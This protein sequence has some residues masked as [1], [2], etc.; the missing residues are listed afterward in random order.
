M[1]YPEDPYAA[2]TASASTQPTGR[3]KPPGM[4]IWSSPAATVTAT[5]APTPNPTVRP[6]SPLVA[7]PP[8]EPRSYLD[9]LGGM[10]SRRR[11]SRE[12]R[13]ADRWF[14]PDTGMTDR[15]DAVADARRAEQR[16]AA[17]EAERAA[18]LSEREQ[19][20]AAEMAQKQ[21]NFEVDQE[22]KRLGRDTITNPEGDRVYTDTMTDW[23]V[24]KQAEQEDALK[25]AEYRREGRSFY[26]DP[27]TK[28][29]APEIPD[30]EWRARQQERAATDRSKAIE[31]ARKDL[32]TAE[33][34]T[35]DTLTA[36]ERRRLEA[37]QSER[38]T[39]IRAAL[40]ERLASDPAATETTGGFLGFGAR[41]TDRAASLAARRNELETGGADPTPEEWAALEQDEAWRP[42]VQEYRQAQAQLA[43]DDEN[44]A[45]H[46]DRERRRLDQARDAMAALTGAPGQPANRAEGE[47]PTQPTRR[48]AVH[49]T[50]EAAGA[51]VS[52]PNQA[53]G[54]Q[55]PEQKPLSPADYNAAAED[56]QYAAE[57]LAQRDAVLSDQIAMLDQ[58]AAALVERGLSE[59]E[60]VTLP[61]GRVYPRA[62]VP[63]LIDL[64]EKQFAHQ[65]D[66]ASERERLAAA[67]EPLRL[68]GEQLRQQVE[69][70]R[71]E[72]R[73]QRAQW[74]AD[75]R[76]REPA[77]APVADEIEA[78][79]RE[80][81]S[82]IDRAREQFEPGPE[83]AAAL[84]T[85]T[86]DTE[87]RSGELIQRV[88]GFEGVRD[89]IGQL[90]VSTA[91]EM[92]RLDAFHAQDPASRKT[93]ADERQQAFSDAWDAA[94]ELAKQAGLP[95]SVVRPVWYDAFHASQP[96]I[97]GEQARALHGSGRALI[98]PAIAFDDKA[99]TAALEKLEA[100]ASAKQQAR[101]NLPAMRRRLAVQLLPTLRE[102]GDFRR[103]EAKNAHR[104]RG[105]DDDPEAGMG[106]QAE[107]EMATAYFAEMTP[108]RKVL[109][110]VAEGL[111]AGAHDIRTQ[112]HALPAAVSTLLADHWLPGLQEYAATARSLAEESAARAQQ[113]AAAAATTPAQI[114]P[115]VSVADLSRG[116]TS[117]APV[118]ATGGLTGGLVRAGAA[119]SLGRIG[120]AALRLSGGGAAVSGGMSATQAANLA[121]QIGLRGASGMAFV[122]SFGGT[123]VDARKNYLDQG[124]S[125]TEAGDAALRNATLAGLT[126]FALTRLGGRFGP[127][128]LLAGDITSSRTAMGAAELVKQ[129]A[130][131]TASRQM[132]KREL[133]NLGKQLFLNA[134]GEGIEEWADETIQ[135]L[136]TYGT[137]AQ[138]GMTLH[139][140][141]NQGM[142][143]GWI[144][145]GLGGGTVAIQES[146]GGMAGALDVMRNRGAARA[147]QKR[148]ED[149][150]ATLA[151]IDAWTGPDRVPEGEQWTDQDTAAAKARA[152]ALTRIAAGVDPATLAPEELAAVGLQKKGGK[153]EAAK[154]GLQMADYE[155]EPMSQVEIGQEGQ[156]TLTPASRKWLDTY[157]PKV[158]RLTADLET[159]TQTQTNEQDPAP[160][161]D[162]PGQDP[163]PSQEQQVPQSGDLSALPAQEAAAAGNEPEP[164][165][166]VPETPPAGLTAPSPVVDA[167]LSDPQPNPVASPTAPSLIENHEPR[168]KNQEQQTQQTLDEP[169]T[170]H[171]RVLANLLVDSRQWDPAD[172]RAVAAEHVARVGI[173]EA[174]PRVQM[175]KHLLPEIEQTL[176]AKGK[177]ATSGAEMGQR[178]AAAMKTGRL[179]VE[180]NGRVGD[181]EPAPDT[182]P[183]SYTPQPTQTPEPATPGDRRS[184][185]STATRRALADRAADLEALGITIRERDENEDGPQ[186]IWADPELGEIAIRP[187]VME[188]WYGPL[189]GN[190]GA[191]ALQIAATI[192][193]ELEHFA[194]FEAGLAMI[195]DAR[196]AQGKDPL[197]RR[198]AISAFKGKMTE[199]WKDFEQR[200]ARTAE[201]FGKLYNP[202][203]WSQ[204]PAYSRGMEVA[205]MLRQR[206]TGRFG[207]M[208]TEQVYS[209][210]FGNRSQITE[211]SA[212]ALEHVLGLKNQPGLPLT[213]K[214]RDILRAVADF[215]RGIVGQ[216]KQGA[217]PQKGADYLLE[218]LEATEAVLETRRGK[219][220]ETGRPGDR[221]TQPS[222]PATGDFIIR[223]SKPDEVWEIT[224]IIR[225]GNE[226]TIY[227]RKRGSRGSGRPIGTLDT[228][229]DNWQP[230]PKE[231]ARA[232]MRREVA[233]VAG[234]RGPDTEGSGTSRSMRFSGL[235][236]MMSPAEWMQANLSP[237][238]QKLAADDQVNREALLTD[239]LDAIKVAVQKGYPI[240]ESARDYATRRG[241]G[242]KL[243][244][245]FFQYRRDSEVGAYVFP[246]KTSPLQNSE[247]PSLPDSPSSKKRATLTRRPRAPRDRDDTPVLNY[248]RESKI[249]AK[250]HPGAMKRMAAMGRARKKG[251]PP[252]PGDRDYFAAWDGAPKLADQPAHVRPYL[253]GIFSRTQGLP[254]DEMA[255]ELASRGLI[256]PDGR[257]GDMY[258]AIDREL[259]TIDRDLAPRGRDEQ[260]NPIV[261]PEQQAE[262]FARDVLSPDATKEERLTNELQPG[263]KLT[264]EGGETLRVDRVLQDGRVVLSDGQTY[265]TQIIQEE[266]RI[267]VDLHQRENGEVVEVDPSLQGFGAG[268][269]ADGDLET[270]RQGNGESP[271]FQVS[272][273]PSLPLSEYPLTNGGTLRGPGLHSLPAAPPRLYH[274]TP[275]K[276]DRFSLDKIGTGEGAQVYGWGLY[277]AEEQK[278]ARG[279]RDGLSRRQVVYRG[280][281]GED[282]FP[283]SGD[284]GSLHTTPKSV[285]AIANGIRSRV[286]NG[287]EFTA[288]LA[289][290]IIESRKRTL[291]QMISE[292]SSGLV[293]FQ[294]GD[295][296]DLIFPNG[297]TKPV[298]NAIRIL[299]ENRDELDQI[300]ANDFTYDSGNLYTIELEADEDEFLDW[301][302]PLSEQSETVQKNLF[303]LV[304]KY[305]IENDAIVR[306]DFKDA[307]LD[308]SVLGSKLYFTI[309]GERQ[310]ET[311]ASDS[312]KAG[313]EILKDS[314]IRGIRYLDGSSRLNPKSLEE[315]R[316][317]VVIARR[318]AENAPQN[319][320]Y[321]K[322]LKDEEGRLAT[323]EQDAQRNTRNYV[324][325]DESIIRIREENGQPVN[326]AEDTAARLNAARPRLPLADNDIQG[327]F[328]F[329]GIPESKQDAARADIDATLS[330]PPGG[331]MDRAASP[332]GDEDRRAAAR[333]HQASRGTAEGIRAAFAGGEQSVSA[334]IH[335]LIRRETPSFEIRGAVIESAEDFRAFLLP[336]RSPFVESVK[337]AVIGDGNQVIHSQ[338]VSIGSVNEAM[339]PRSSI[340]GIIETARAANPDNTV[341]G[342]LIA[343]NHP[344]G[345]VE[346][347]VADRTITN[348]LI[349]DGKLIGVPLLDHVITNGREY[350]SFLES[351]L[352]WGNRDGMVEDDAETSPRLPVLPRP[353]IQTMAP[354]EAQSFNDLANLKD[355][356][357]L[358]PWLES[359]KTGD[360][361]HHHILFVDTRM[362]LRAIERVPTASSPVDLSAR[363]LRGAGREGAAGFFISLANSKMPDANS[364]GVVRELRQR[365]GG[366]DLYFHD[367][368]IWRSGNE[369][370]F[371][372]REMGLMEESPGSLYAARPSNFD[373]TLADLEKRVARGEILTTAERADLERRRDAAGMLAF[374]LDDATVS[375]ET[376]QQRRQREE[377]EQRR[378]QRLIGSDAGEDTDLFT[379]GT[380]DGQ[381]LLFAA[382]PGSRRNG[383]GFFDFGLSGELTN[384]PNQIA[385]DFTAPA[386]VSP[387]PLSTGSGRAG[388]HAGDV[389][390]VHPPE[391]A[392]TEGTATIIGEVPSPN[393]ADP[394]HVVRFE[395]DPSQQYTR[396]ESDF[397]PA[398]SPATTQPDL[399]PVAPAIGVNRDFGEKIGDARKDLAEKS[400]RT[401]K[402]K[403]AKPDA[404]PAWMKGWDIVQIVSEV[405]RWG[406]ST[407]NAGKWTFS[408]D[409][410]RRNSFYY[411]RNPVYDTRKE[412]ERMLP[413]FVV[414]QK[415]RVYRDRDNETQYA[416]FRNVTDRKRVVIKGGF[417]T[418]EDALRYMAENAKE[419]LET[420]TGH[421]EEILSPR[422]DQPIYRKGPS[423]RTRPADAALFADTF[424][425][426]GVEFGN[427]VT[428]E[429]GQDVL[430]HA[431][432]G[433]MDLAEFLNV[434]PRALSLNGEL[435]LAF[436][437]R[438]QGLSGARA[439]YERDRVV[440][441]LTKMKG[442]GSLAHEWMHAVDHYFARQEGRA[443]SEWEYLPD[444]TRRLKAKAADSDFMTAGDY[445]RTSKLRPEVA[446]AWK[447]LREIMTRK[448]VQKEID[449]TQAQKWADKSLNEM[450]GQL[451]AVRAGLAKE[452]PYGSRKAPATADQLARWDRAVESL[453]SGGAGEL[454]WRAI[455]NSAAKWGDYAW[456]NDAFDELSKIHKEVRNRAG[457]KKEGGAL[458]YAIGYYRDYRRREKKLEMANAGEQETQMV[459]TEYAR[460]AHLGD[461]GR[462]GDYWS[463]PW[464]MAARAFSSYIEDKAAASSVHSGFLSMGSTEADN[465]FFKMFYGFKPYP[466]KAERTAIN[467]ALDGLFGSLKT[468]ETDTGTRL[469]A[470]RPVQSLLDT[471]PA[472]PGALVNG[473]LQGRTL[474]ESATE[475]GYP[476][477]VTADPDRL[478]RI[479][480]QT[481]LVLTQRAQSAGLTPEQVREGFEAIS[482]TL[483][484]AAPTQNQAQSTKNKR[485]PGQSA[486]DSAAI[487]LTA[488]VGRASGFTGLADSL[489]R[490]YESAPLAR[491]LRKIIDIAR[492][493]AVPLHLLDREVTSHMAEM[494]VA[495]A[496]GQE[497][498]MDVL[499][500]VSGRAKFSD[501]AWPKQY[502][503]DAGMRRRLWMAMTGNGPGLDT[504]PP[505]VATIGRRMRTLLED[506]G[507]KAVREGRM[508]PDTF[509]DLRGTYLPE[510]YLEHELAQTN[511][512]VGIFRKLKLGMNEILAQRMTGFRIEDTE[513]KD[514]TGQ[515]KLVTYT[516]P[517]S[518]RQRWRFRDR[519]H[520]DAYWE[521]YT[522][523]RAVEAMQH[524]AQTAKSGLPRAEQDA[525]RALPPDALDR[526]EQLPDVIRGY[527]AGHLATMRRRYRREKPLTIA[528]REKAG[529]IMDPVYSV[530][531]YL[532]HM[533]H[534]NATAKFFHIL[535]ADAT[536]KK[537]IGPAN[538]DGYTQIPDHAKF[539]ALRSKWVKNEIASQVME[540]VGASSD[541]MRAYDA[542]MTLFKTGKTVWNPGTHIRNVL[543]NV[544]FA[545]LAGV[546]PLN[547]LNAPHYRNA[548]QT[549]WKGG[550]TLEEMYREGV[551]GG[552]FLTAELRG[553]LQSLLPLDTVETAGDPWMKLTVLLQKAVRKSGAS[554]LKNWVENAYQLEDEVYKAAAYLK[555]KQSGMDP[556]AAAAHVRKWFAYYDQ[557]GTSGSIKLI[558]RTAMPF[559]S[560]QREALRILGNAARERPIALAYTLALPAILTQISFALL[561]IGERDKEEVRKTLNGKGRFFGRHTPLFSMLL[562]KRDG[563]GRL[564]Q[565][566]LTNVMPFASLLGR[567]REFDD[568]EPLLQSLA[569]DFIAGSPIVGLPLEVATN[570]DFFTGNRLW[571]DN[572]TGTE[573]ARQIAAQAWSTLM[574]PLV[575]PIPG[576]TNNDGGMDTGGGTGWNMLAQAG[577][578]RTNRSL[579]RRNEGQSLARGLVGIDIKSAAPSIYDLVDAYMEARGIPR[580]ESDPPGTTPES[581]ARRRIWDA[582]V[583]GTDREATAGDEAEALRRAAEAERAIAEEMAY[584]RSR[585]R[586][587]ETE[588]D[589]RRLVS[590]RNPAMVFSRVEDRQD[591]ERNYLRD[592][593][594]TA[595]AWREAI[596]AY[597]STLARGKG[598]LTRAIGKSRTVAAQ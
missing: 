533:E 209:A 498:A 490:W 179:G 92:A 302:K 542:T 410:D 214:F 130:A 149:V 137:N 500:A 67:A 380:A 71:L 121:S 552:D 86:R 15:L 541:A 467:A 390:E 346:P 275:H 308:G 362:K 213:D 300:S 321:A 574:P 517:G 303:G 99:V 580:T 170:E 324:I 363:I 101:E 205:R 69:T 262:N 591:F 79:E 464:E 386:E 597:E 110:Q 210:L 462:T 381:G 513:E 405:N 352:L 396:H 514:E 290:E 494:R 87:A 590:L 5:P 247:S 525:I 404:K 551:L 24:R 575:P 64:E 161:P 84:D 471:L 430:N 372:Y 437:A 402:P 499:R 260:G 554:H 415:H 421:G 199:A 116:A 488:A 473:L 217:R 550:E 512:P 323:L 538:T 104:F 250:N 10:P 297:D 252:D 57:E 505:E 276:V 337:I 212:R 206:A 519:D 502:A 7:A 436:G 571:E 564:A 171:A 392:Q 539:G 33:A 281:F 377:L 176:G 320:I 34:A 339:V 140:V 547:P 379:G 248:I 158:A 501:L 296:T 594:E 211:Q 72:Q 497:Q 545:H 332:A 29:I 165:S 76:K 399:L 441:N 41:P 204:M 521:T 318:D 553:Q 316:A 14:A 342:F 256:P 444:G 450:R 478:Q 595:Q 156:A 232:K 495:Q 319:P 288:N 277:F 491:P 292:K 129:L 562:P 485:P 561:G 278:V 353:P 378:N 522:R 215:L 107:S 261:D 143:A 164:V 16:L 531:K 370:P 237:A 32:E 579:E 148:A 240:S 125:D 186:A 6:G 273:F 77:L 327:Y 222:T 371:S 257:F 482:G 359:L 42:A 509:E 159:Q 45:W 112:F 393:P 593:P 511:T 510:Y 313:S 587:I 146:A 294:K 333:W 11:E 47:L 477:P 453:V 38:Q 563:E 135:G 354:W 409:T 330:I 58:R 373:P 147:E 219:D 403:A 258:E 489:A 289:Q 343:H 476:E 75:L 59:Q 155:L 325:F 456:S 401:E 475:A 439:H 182:S 368:I 23:A 56:Y 150:A 454:A 556:K 98:N 180:E 537:W 55:N 295:S 25:E 13:P 446:A 387:E 253:E 265:G 389:V 508:H 152:K 530:A 231:S 255:D 418:E 518:S 126:T 52:Q 406:D 468:E 487:R 251:L 507:M 400:G 134:S 223:K 162:R 54:T 435:A 26:T 543:G 44:R 154:A 263:D 280:A 138:P 443:S 239:Y 241:V 109:N 190:E 203:M 532:A 100:S 355:Q 358:A 227:G 90:A 419:I 78:L 200:H 279:Y 357:D 447:Q 483:Y 397:V 119:G 12:E 570:Q 80:T 188:Q 312:R 598:I 127:E 220:S 221:E 254:P 460:E 194:T 515:D 208:T 2:P 229:A 37:R 417:A 283:I 338:V 496:F 68:A 114:L 523:R 310:I 360:P 581:R 187:A 596:R 484:A 555:A 536:G 408:K 311:G 173:V 94:R 238:L 328:D 66:T 120:Q 431:Y 243:E 429:E 89:Q 267:Y 448:T 452:A 35:R 145:A 198:A 123:Y 304:K 141:I 191:L 28:R 65:R 344:S 367:A 245:R 174:E 549:I 27:L 534:D 520:R 336:L 233:E 4:P 63:D 366:N 548:L 466:E 287:A 153:V 573:K 394:L 196:A 383:Q 272:P 411:P 420:K 486:L 364:T 506:A 472:K 585:G 246:G 195:Q 163:Q 115:F 244:N 74:T 391:S 97:R 51:P 427:W 53:P 88:Q 102:S 40:A 169:Q 317:R 193:E 249:L 128:A 91:T 235:E 184:R 465:L 175:L 73:A 568:A 270:R 271:P 524:W 307:V 39:Q 85:I 566:D 168:T 160:T 455:P 18:A 326:L 492:R 329:N 526:M 428:S 384:D 474:A 582:L 224:T 106:V 286:A 432:D 340:S 309:S 282:Q 83:L 157:F 558:R 298:E 31:S 527:A 131:G 504:L 382:R 96:W 201:L 567:R 22:A 46:D 385:F 584:L 108:G 480:R 50:R 416:I 225:A 461:M 470:A 139:D 3:R 291:D 322:I 576:V 43:T 49:G 347:S 412:A 438:G 493:E 578:R 516:E 374:G 398:E 117:L 529:L 228:F 350:L 451:D 559:F 103:W 285:F 589:V 166:G 442:A 197:P 132:F 449:Q 242:S 395:D 349:E 426:R 433:L 230:A 118:V 19:R 236:A 425:F 586:P 361:D 185:I 202:E 299:Q 348:R 535:A 424:Q 122:Q 93:A 172:A 407:P 8:A 445:L 269:A 136:I 414:S 218:L 356:Y 376:L 284:V 503:N 334:L 105:A 293:A 181:E 457:L 335:S 274:G 61:D 177:A 113:S 178:A 60:R 479:A 124:Y 167:T 266:D 305:I 314:G 183:E 469:Y 95:E 17:T 592:R 111:E 21:R 30:A 540:L 528:E 544:M 264:V 207:G 565:F 1:P 36:E 569:K 9:A 440:I 259:R 81:R 142:T 577:E 234:S 226:G 557:I 365:F 463:H 459:P 151:G 268:R 422:D 20:A 434:P 588:S 369:Q 133:T 48:D 572:M 189:A 301:D 216:P 583:K 331:G 351:G 315:A 388:Y 413:A 62:L 458:E 70:A 144:G 560:F 341:R 423:R 192:D 345:E 375:P 481:G 306:Q 82:R 546:N